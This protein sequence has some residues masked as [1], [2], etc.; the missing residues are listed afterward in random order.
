MTR[1]L[2]LALAALWLAP[3]ARAAAVC[4]GDCN[5]DGRVSIAEVQNCVNLAAGLQAPACAAADADGSG[6]VESNDVDLCVDSFLDPA[7]CQMAATPKPTNTVPPTNTPVSTNTPVPTATRTNTPLP[8]PTNTTAP[9]NTPTPTATVAPLGKRE[10]KLNGAPGSTLLLQTQAFPLPA[11]GATG[12]IEIDCGAPGADG[13]AACTCGVKSFGTVVI[14]SIG[15]VCVNPFPGCAP[16]RFDCDGGVG[17]DVDLSTNHNIGTC[18]SNAQCLTACQARCGSLG[19]TYEPLTYGCEG[20]CQGGTN[21]EA[22]CLRDSE[23]P[24]GQCVGAEPVSHIGTCNCSC[25]G[26]S[27]GAAAPAGSLTCNVGTQIDVE[28]PSDGDCLDAN[29]IVLAGVCGG[30][31]TSTSTGQLI[32]VNNSSGTNTPP[33]PRVMTGAPISCANYAAGNVNGLKLVGQLGF[34]DSTLGDILSQN[35]FTCSQP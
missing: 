19:A 11:F 8:T 25:G 33:Q 5:G 26:D 32:N 14:P 24:G 35:T 1:A 12:V 27:L 18:S 30:V 22:S 2:L 10:C 3:A 16:G 6:S 15:D 28:L 23:C 21:E 4:A 29:T 31:T 34:F 9:T 7:T 13:A 20:Y 17:T